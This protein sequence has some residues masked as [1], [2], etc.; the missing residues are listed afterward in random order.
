MT[1][2]A[3]PSSQTI[4][5]SLVGVDNLSCGYIL[6]WSIHNGVYDLTTLQA[7]AAA[8]D[9]PSVIFS[10]LIAETGISAWNKAT[11]IDKRGIASLDPDRDCTARYVIKEVTE[12]TRLLVRER[13]SKTQRVLSIAQVAVLSFDGGFKYDPDVFYMDHKDEVDSIVTSMA[14]DYGNRIGQIDDARIRH[15][16]LN[17]TNERHAIAARKSGGIYYL[18]HRDKLADEIMNIATFFTINNIGTLASIEIFQAP[19]TTLDALVESASEELT[20]EVDNL[21]AK[22]DRLI[23]NYKDDLSALTKG[24]LTPSQLAMKTG[25]YGY[26]VTAYQTA[27]VELQEKLQAV[28]GSLGR[29][30]G[31]LGTR[32]S[33]MIGKADKVKARAD[34]DT[35]KHGTAKPKKSTAVQ[36][37]RLKRKNV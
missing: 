1:V 19:G 26:T 17:W 25:S 21:T 3:Q 31:Q 32:L 37:G 20:S 34:A 18:P 12:G 35:G 29:T 8:K 7:S 4:A 10:G 11:A 22:L 13:V 28:E 23:E 9:V 14:T 15:V 36:G 33:M 6:W 2:T 16:L 30:L 27:I 24:G 5:R